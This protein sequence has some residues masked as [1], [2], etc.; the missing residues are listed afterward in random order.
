M[1]SKLRATFGKAFVLALCVLLTSAA[2]GGAKYRVLHN[3]GPS[4]DG[5]QPSG[6][7]LLGAKGNLYGVTVTGGGPGGGGY[8]C[9]T[10]FELTATGNGKWTERVLHAFAD[11]GDGAIPEGNLVPDAQGN[12]YGTTKGT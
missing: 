5:T 11:Q 12:L 7:L 8:G 3:F 10:V 1:K 4:G 9:G 6:P 2:W